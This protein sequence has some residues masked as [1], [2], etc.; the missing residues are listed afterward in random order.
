M[1]FGVTDKEKKRDASYI[2][3]SIMLWRYFL[4]NFTTLDS[5][6]IVL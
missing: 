1:F 5:S 2:D 4:I 6:N 3:I